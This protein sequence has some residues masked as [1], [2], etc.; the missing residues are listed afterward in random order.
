MVAMQLRARGAWGFASDGIHDAAFLVVAQGA[1]WLRV[2]GPPPVQLVRGDGIMLPGGSP[3]AL[4]SSRSGRAQPARKVL[5][6][7]PPGEDG[8]ADLGGSGPAAHLI[9]GEFTFEHDQAHP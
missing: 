8:V 2:A 1:C 5:A 9:C 6:E 4:T 3:R 7:H